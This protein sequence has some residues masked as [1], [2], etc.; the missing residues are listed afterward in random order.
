MGGYIPRRS[1]KRD[2]AP[3]QLVGI[4]PDEGEPHGG[5]TPPYTFVSVESRVWSHDGRNDWYGT[6]GND[7]SKTKGLRKAGGFFLVFGPRCMYFLSD[8]NLSDVY[9]LKLETCISS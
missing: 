7:M 4:R 8:V 9:L 5:S 1:N 6:R 3:S 2:P